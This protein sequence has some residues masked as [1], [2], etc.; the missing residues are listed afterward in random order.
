MDK[1]FHNSFTQESNIWKKCRCA[2]F[3]IAAV[4]SCKEQ[5]FLIIVRFTSPLKAN[6]VIRQTHASMFTFCNTLPFHYS[7]VNRILRNFLQTESLLIGILL[8]DRH[9]SH[10]AGLLK[11]LEMK[12]N[13]FLVI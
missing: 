6:R 1:F 10:N 8:V 13:N 7:A 9:P 5:T 12:E 4:N 11:L 2:G 3:V